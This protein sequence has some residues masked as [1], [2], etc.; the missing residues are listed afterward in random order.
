MTEVVRVEQVTTAW[1]SELLGGRVDGVSHAPIGTGQ[2]GATYRFVLTGDGVPATLVGKFAATDE[3]SRAT[4]V[5]QNSYARETGFY[6]RLARGRTLP[7][8]EIDYVSF[9]AATHD[10]ALMMREIVGARAGDQLVPLSREEAETAVDAIAAVHGAFWADPVLDTLD[11]LPG[12]ALLPH[13]P[14]DPLYAMLW[15][16]FVDRYGDR[17]TPTMR[18]VGEALLD[19]VDE[20]IAND[21]PKTLVHGDYR[22]DNMLFDPKGAVTIVDWQTC[23]AGRGARDLAYFAGTSLAPAD[24]GLWERDLFDRWRKGLGVGTNANVEWVEYRRSAFAGFLMAVAASMIV[25][26]TERGDAMF[27][28][29]GERAAAMVLE[30]GSISLI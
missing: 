30:L 14:V 1:L 11:W 23:A 28:T 25:G 2:V 27:L 8:P 20:W 15:P 22:H 6:D 19:H 24:R 12:S 18:E 17:V 7:I 16:A 21:G 3:V 4:G 9:D 5:A 26:R 13:S 10:F 29:M